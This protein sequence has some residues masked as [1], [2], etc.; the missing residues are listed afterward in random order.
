MK[1]HNAV[2]KSIYPA[3]WRDEALKAVF[4]GSSTTSKTNPSATGSPGP[5][6]HQLQGG[7]RILVPL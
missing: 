3:T 1:D 2:A 7:S 5:L 4:G 6:C